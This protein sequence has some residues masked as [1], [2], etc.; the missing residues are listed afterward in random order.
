[1]KILITTTILIHVPTSLIDDWM[2]TLFFRVW[3]IRSV[4]RVNI[5]IW[6]EIKPKQDNEDVQWLNVFIELLSLVESK[7]QSTLS[8]TTR[9][10]M[11]MYG[12]SLMSTRQ[13]KHL[14]VLDNNGFLWRGTG[15][16]S[17]IHSNNTFAKLLIK[18]IK[19]KQGFKKDIQ[20]WLTNYFFFLSLNHY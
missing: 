11:Y 4:T 18:L 5:F 16:I 6:W 1:M 7:V 8:C 3:T 20:H 10:K 2:E 15:R 19:A 12:L 9:Y 14:N 17:C 13:N